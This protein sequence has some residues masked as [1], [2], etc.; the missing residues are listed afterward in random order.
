MR[1]SSAYEILNL[2]TGPSYKQIQTTWEMEVCTG[3]VEFGTH[4][5]YETDELSSM[6]FGLFATKL[7]DSS[8]GGG[9]KRQRVE[10]VKH[11][12]SRLGFKPFKSLTLLNLLSQAARD[13]IIHR[14]KEKSLIFHGF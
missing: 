11:I 9:R 12:S 7:P 3:Y 6:D 5:V 1:R 4:L 2:L 8:R 14:Q 13:L 10:G